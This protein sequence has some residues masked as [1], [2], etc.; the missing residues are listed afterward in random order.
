MRFGVTLPP[1][2]ALADPRRLADLAV[3]AEAAGW[4]G[5]FVWDHVYYRPPVRAVSDPWTALAAIAMQTSRVTI[6]P[7]VTPLARRRPHVVA[8]QV[9]ALDALS[10]GRFV[11]GVGLGLDRSGGELVRFGEEA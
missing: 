8:R 4:D 10:N 2:D 5:C 11:L 6:G 9:V 1:F 3:A 7:M